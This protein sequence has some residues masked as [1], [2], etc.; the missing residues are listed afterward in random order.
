MEQQAD[1]GYPSIVF[2][3]GENFFSVDSRYIS[4][5][6]QLP[7]YE[8]IPDAP[9]EIA[10]IFQH[11][12][13]AVTMYN[14]RA[15]L[16]MKSLDDEFREF[17]TMIGERKKDHLHWVET[18]EHTAKTGEPFTLATDS[19][20]CA[21]GKWCDQFESEINEVNFHL[22]KIEEPHQKLHQAGLE[23]SAIEGTHDS[24]AY[25]KAVVGILERVRGTY[26][27]AVLSLLD[28]TVEIFRT[29]FFHEMVLI[30]SGEGNMSLVVDQVLSVEHLSPVSSS[31]AFDAFSRVPFLTRIERSEKIPELILRLDIPLLL[32]RIKVPCCVG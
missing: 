4:M 1:I 5:I 19:H 3:V 24:P 29:A 30:L 25:Q 6:M 21:L 9:P 11:R 32:D 13:T 20:Q 14:L 2:K 23:L 22:R 18:L 12:D 16:K 15:A 28:R 8:K 10:G 31:T 7:K 17:Q 26:M 27:P